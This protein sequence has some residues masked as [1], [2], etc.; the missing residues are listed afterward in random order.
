MGL[1][2]SI[3]HLATLSCNAT[4]AKVYNN[5]SQQNIATR[6]YHFTIQIINHTICGNMRTGVTINHAAYFVNIIKTK[7]TQNENN[8]TTTRNTTL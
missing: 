4:T 6:F 7:K 8:S 1:Q 3:L 5:K 2:N